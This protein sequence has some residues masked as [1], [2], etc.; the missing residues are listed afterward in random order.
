MMQVDVPQQL[1]TRQLGCC[2]AKI[3]FVLLKIALLWILRI[4][5]LASM[6]IEKVY[7]L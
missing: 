6:S 5:S 3:A 1:P 4:I 2:A 7:F